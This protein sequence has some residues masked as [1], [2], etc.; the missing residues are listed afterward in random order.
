MKTRILSCGTLEKEVRLAMERCHAQIPLEILKENNHDVPRKLSMCIQEKLDQ[1]EDADRVLM[2]FGTC[3]GAMVGLHSGNAEMII[4]RVDDCLS[5]L[6]G[7]MEQRYASAGKG[8]GVFLTESWLN[9]E[10]SME[11]ELD[12]IERMYPPTRAARVIQS[13]YRNFDCLNVIDTGAYDVSS[14]LPRTQALAQ[15]LSLKHQVVQGTTAYLEELL[16]GPWDPDRF[17]IIPP[18]TTVTEEHVRVHL[19]SPQLIGT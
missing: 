9:H 19:T 16:Q 6:M 8:F 15:R 7:S 11:A 14:I 18:G 5:L 4:P 2:A 1:M 10:K 13:L 17:I 12:R 3:G